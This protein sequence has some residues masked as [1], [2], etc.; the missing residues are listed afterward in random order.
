MVGDVVGSPGR[1]AIKTILPQLRDE[2]KIDLVTANAENTAG[3]FGLT[4]K[5]G[6]ELINSGVDVLTSG[7]HIWDKKE[8]I[9]HMDGDLPLIRPLNY[10]PNVPGKGYMNLDRVTV[11]NVMGRVFLNTIDC[12]FRAMDTFLNNNSE[13]SDLPIIVDM[14]AEATSEKQA[15]GWYLDG[16]ISALVGTHTH[17]ATADTRILPNGTA[18]VTDLGM[19]GPMDSVIGTDSD[20]IISKFLHQT[21]IRFTI[22]DGPIRFNSV[23]INI[24]TATNKATSIERID[25]EI[26]Q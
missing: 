5:T 4:M 11:V 25:R 26:S 15:L 7:N 8:I 23:L 20:T 6:L 17:V 10:P 18:Y 21:P 12:P 24:D 14:H 1:Q 13:R 9:P 16:R 22:A 2:Y 19:V 3:G